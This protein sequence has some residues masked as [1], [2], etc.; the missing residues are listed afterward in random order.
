MEDLTKIREDIDGVDEQLLNLFKKRLRLAC[1]VADYKIAH[2]RPVLDKGR[3]EAKL[4]HL[5]EGVKD[6]FLEL[7]IRE[8]FSLIMSISRKKQYQMLAENGIGEDSGF[9]CVNSFNLT[10][11][12]VVYQGVEGAYSQAATNDVFGKDVDS[13]HVATWREA[14]DALRENRADFAVLP[15]ENSTAG[16]VSQ[17]LDL[18]NE[19]DCA[20]IGE[21]VIKIDHAL[22]STKDAT[23]DTIK[24]VYSHPQALMQ[25]ADYLRQH[26]QFTS[27]STT[28]TAVAA[29]KV[30]DDNDPSEA[31][32]AGSINADL[33]GL[34][35]IDSAIQDVKDNETRFLIVSAKKIFRRD[36]K[37][38]SICFTLPNEEGSLYQIL[39]HFAFNGLNMS[40]IESRPLKGRPWEYRFFV[41]FEGN[42]LDEGVVNALLGLRC[43]TN[44]LKILGNY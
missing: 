15:I 28:N 3:E 13:F 40:R 36:A 17:N 29:K 23:I 25:C 14:M 26:E 43:E 22:L 35:V 2:H 27:V 7:G 31:A 37:N 11:A 39:T 41:D 33:Y 8:F 24:R 42:L 10:N 9:T 38:I 34:K 21:K 4:S 12:K 44:D 18:L 20:I 32:I 5:T 16:T 19:Y 30:K 6:E 1:E